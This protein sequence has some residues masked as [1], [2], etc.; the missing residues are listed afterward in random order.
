M[1]K[2]EGSEGDWFLQEVGRGVLNPKRA[3]MRAD[4]WGEEGHIFNTDC[5]VSIATPSHLLL[6]T[7]TKDRELDSSSAW[8]LDPTELA[9]KFTSR[10]K[11]LILNTPNNPLGKVTESLPSRDPSRLGSSPHSVTDLLPWGLSFF[12]CEVGGLPVMSSEDRGLW[13]S[14]AQGQ[15]SPGNV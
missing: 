3:S 9:S 13:R 12:I 15:H 7:P 2:R 8:Q 6:Q 10:T 5:E 1:G 14:Q 4:A 11:A